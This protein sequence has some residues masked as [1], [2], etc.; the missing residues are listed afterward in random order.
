MSWPAAWRCVDT[1]SELQQAG[2]QG[3]V[4]STNHSSPGL[5]RVVLQRLLRDDLLHVGVLDGG[6]EVL[7]GGH[8][9]GHVAQLQLLEEVEDLLLGQG[10]DGELAQAAVG[11]VGGQDLV[12][13]HLLVVDVQQAPVLQ[14]DTVHFD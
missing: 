3:G 12:V 1:V 14:P 9:L 2:R 7:G 11:L 5:G 6:E 4:Q 10:H 8:L 13:G